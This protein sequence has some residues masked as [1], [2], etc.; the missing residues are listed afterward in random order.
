[1]SD[2][3]PPQLTRE[4]FEHLLAF[5][6]SLRRFQRWSEDQAKAAGLTHV[7][8]Q[9]LVAIKGHPGS[10]PPTVG[11]LAEYL[12]LRHH[13]AVELLDRAVAAGLVRRV[14]DARDG[15]VARV[16]LTAKGD[17]ILMQLTPSHLLELHSLA[18]ILDDLVAAEDRTGR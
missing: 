9:L 7:Q 15:R 4:D 8:H 13:S 16:R 1:M 17:R 6:T 18:A 2:D 11:D 12:L 5:R 14:T 10:E 3:E